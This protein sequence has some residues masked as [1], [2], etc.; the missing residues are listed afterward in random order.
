MYVSSSM[1][2]TRLL[3]FQKQWPP[4]SCLLTGD[5]YKPF[6]GTVTGGRAP[7]YI[8]IYIIYKYTNYGKCFNA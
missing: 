5:P 1:Y 8:I 2:I 6:L 7:Q 4:E 3:P